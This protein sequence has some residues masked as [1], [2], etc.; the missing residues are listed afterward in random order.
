MSE[1]AGYLLAVCA[2][3]ISTSTRRS[4][5]QQG[6]VGAL[7][8]GCDS[9]KAPVMILLAD[10]PALT[11]ASLIAFGRIRLLD[12]L[13]AET[14]AAIGMLYTEHFGFCDLWTI[15]LAGGLARLV[16]TRDFS[17]LRLFFVHRTHEF[18]ERRSFDD[19]I[20]QS[21]INLRHN[22]LQEEF[23]QGAHGEPV[24]TSALARSR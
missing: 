14:R 22:F 9:P 13:A 24:V 21:R 1:F 20:E 6:S 15:A 8:L 12:F 11:S 5:C 2:L 3:P 7:H 10:T 19:P 4:L 16:S 23:L 17:R 18:R